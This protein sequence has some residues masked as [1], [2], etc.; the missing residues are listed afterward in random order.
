MKNQVALKP[1]FSTKFKFFPNFMT[2]K[3]CFWVCV[4]KI[5]QAWVCLPQDPF[6]AIF[7]VCSTS[8][9]SLRFSDTPSNCL[10]AGFSQRE[11]LVVGDWREEGREEGRSQRITHFSCLL[12]P[13]GVST[14]ICIFSIAPSFLDISIMVLTISG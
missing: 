6:L 10:P 2:F 5:C 8:E 1:K 7:L 4:D 3:K 14:S 11:T 12:S 9:S 13:R